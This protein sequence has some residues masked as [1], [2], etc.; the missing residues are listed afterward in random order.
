VGIGCR[1][2]S[3]VGKYKGEG[4]Q[5]VGIGWEMEVTRGEIEERGR[6]MGGNRV[7]DGGH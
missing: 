1:W 3:I 7:G 4:G 5:W 6:T 2:R